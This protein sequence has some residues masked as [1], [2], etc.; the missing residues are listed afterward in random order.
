LFA[1]LEKHRLFKTATQRNMGQFFGQFSM[2][3]PMHHLNA[4]LPIM[5][6]VP[7]VRK[8]SKLSFQ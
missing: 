3:V 2:I 5:L 7:K 4:L 6:G 1:I 8:T